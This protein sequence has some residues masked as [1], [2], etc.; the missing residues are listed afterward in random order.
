[1]ESH[2]GTLLLGSDGD[3]IYEIKGGTVVNYS[4]EDGLNDSVVLRM[5][6]DEGDSGYFISAGSSLYYWDESGFRK[7][8][9]RKS[10]GS[11]FDFFT[12]D[13]M[14]WIIQNSGI[15]AFDRERLLAGEDPM[16]RKFSF[17]HGLTGSIDANTWNWQDENGS[18]YLATRSGISVFSFTPVTGTLPKGIIS[19]VHTDDVFYNRPESVEIEK[20]VNRVTIDFAVLS[21]AETYD[22][23][24]A[25]MLEGFDEAETIITGEKNGSISYTNLPGGEYTFRLR[26]FLLDHPDL[27]DEYSLTLIK[28]PKLWELLPI[29]LLVV[30]L[31][32]LFAA[33]VVAMVYRAKIRGIQKRQQDYRS[34]IEQLLQTFAYT[35]SHPMR[36]AEYARELAR[37]MGKSEEEQENI[38]YVALLHDVGKT[39]DQDELKTCSEEQAPKNQPVMERDTKLGGNATRNF[40]ALRDSA[41]GTKDNYDHYNGKDCRWKLSGTEIPL[42]ARIIAVADAYDTM[43]C[44]CSDREV[45]SSE[46]I[47][48]Q[49]Q[50]GSGAQF[51]PEIVRHMLDMIAEGF[52][53][54]S[55]ET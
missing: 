8:P 27:F 29:K 5:I 55:P 49:L 33:L 43:S 6:W 1:M 37:R 34:I 44:D 46:L 14:V 12:R 20:S 54:T 41:D 10:A 26:I 48:D 23:G 18:L 45:L 47:A 52:T 9:V 36:V 13:G 7:L 42:V 11:I 35:N 19:S 38:Y 2:D 25:Y 50:K 16:P 32:V 3:G 21:F 31:L 53:P 22:V 24:F 30:M 15:L 28:A 17:A 40:T 39:G 4:N 51:D